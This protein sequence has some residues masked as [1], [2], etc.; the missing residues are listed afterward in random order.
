MKKKAPSIRNSKP[1][2]WMVGWTE[3]L[4]MGLYGNII[5]GSNQ[6]NI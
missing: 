5:F 4:K 2:S 3:L 1:Q 6:Q